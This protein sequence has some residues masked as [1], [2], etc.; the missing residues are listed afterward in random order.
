MSLESDISSLH[1]KNTYVIK[2]ISMYPF[3]QLCKS[4][5]A[6]ALISIISFC[7]ALIFWSNDSSINSDHTAFVRNNILWVYITTIASSVG[8]ILV[9]IYH[10]IEYTQIKYLFSNV[11]ISFEGGINYEGDFV[12]WK[13][14]NDINIKRSLFQRIIGSGTVEVVCTDYSTKRLVDV[15]NSIE[16]YR[17]LKNKIGKQLATARRIVRG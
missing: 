12:S 17:Y 7:I 8:I 14:I 10:Y 16:L 3:L 6:G 11:G 15:G 13:Q 5:T 4:S 1:G 2:P 9:W